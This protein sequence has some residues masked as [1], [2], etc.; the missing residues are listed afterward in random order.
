MTTAG[1]ITFQARDT[2]TLVLYAKTHKTSANA[3]I[4]TAI[5]ITS[6]ARED[7]QQ[8]T[9]LLIASLSCP[10]SPMLDSAPPTQILNIF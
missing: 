8:Q 6:R 3:S 4:K 1:N 10:P 7:V 9:L 2:R 5:S